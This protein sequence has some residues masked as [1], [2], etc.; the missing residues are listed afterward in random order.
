[1]ISDAHTNKKPRQ[2][3]FL[4]PSLCATIPFYDTVSI[5]P[6]QKYYKS[7]DERVLF[8][9]IESHTISFKRLIIMIG[10][11]GFFFASFRSFSAWFCFVW[12]G[13]VH[14]GVCLYGKSSFSGFVYWYIHWRIEF[15]LRW[16]ML[17]LT[18]QPFP[19][20][21]FCVYAYCAESVCAC[22]HIRNLFTSL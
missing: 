16:K 7:F 11:G 9:L 13:S 21:P 20:I 12:F 19:F 14:L 15:V 17:V 1:M 18:A 8:A 5:K 22:I 3:A 2:I 4:P 10:V 6:S